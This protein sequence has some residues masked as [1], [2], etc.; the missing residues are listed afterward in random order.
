MWMKGK[1]FYFF[2]VDIIHNSVLLRNYFMPVLIIKSKEVIKIII[3]QIHQ[4]EEVRGRCRHAYAC[5][6][7]AR[8][9][10]THARYPRKVERATLLQESSFCKH[11]FRSC[12][13]TIPQTGLKSFY[14]QRGRVAQKTLERV[15][16]CVLS[17]RM[18]GVFNAERTRQRGLLPL[19]EEQDKKR[20]SLIILFCFIQ[21]IFR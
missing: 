3:R 4:A 7:F 2:I 14:K 5:I 9:V 1:V 16:V 20:N 17:T 11:S 10:H 8:T 15:T 13:C 18:S 21:L 6:Y 19:R 12:E